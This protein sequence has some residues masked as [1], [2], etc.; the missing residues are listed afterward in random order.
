M[1][2]ICGAENEKHETTYYGEEAMK[3]GRERG[4]KRRKLDRRYKMAE[5][6]HA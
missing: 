6:Q 1:A 3:E 2:Q 5:Q 4:R